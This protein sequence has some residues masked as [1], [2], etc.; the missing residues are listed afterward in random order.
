MGKTQ[1][2]K[3]EFYIG[4]FLELKAHSV[5]C[6][7]CRAY[8]YALDKLDKNADILSL[9][10]YDIEKQ[11]YSLRSKY[12]HN[13]LKNI[14][15]TFN[16]F[17]K[18]VKKYY[19]S[20]F[21]LIIEYK[22]NIQDLLEEKYKKKFIE[23]KKI[24]EL[25]HSIKSEYVR[26]Y[27]TVQILTGLRIGEI[28]ALTYEDIDIENKTISVNKTRQRNGEITTPKTVNSFRTIEINDTVLNILLKRKNDEKYI[29]HRP[30]QVIEYEF[31]KLGINSHMLRHTHAVLLLELDIPIKVISERLGHSFISTTLSLYSH[32]GLSLKKDLINKLERIEF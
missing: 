31:R 14:V 4:K 25:L 26:D 29:F 28:R 19:I 17:F 30:V 22:P 6:N 20:D 7:T 9:K 10:K 18:F 8:K 24:S 12:K 16:M 3:V 27:A 13:H 23:P 32:I 11:I 5:S 15:F 21:N 1:I 2:Y